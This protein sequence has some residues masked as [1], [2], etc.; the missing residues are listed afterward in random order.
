MQSWLESSAYGESPDQP[1][2]TPASPQ[3]AI[4]QPVP[5]LVFPLTKFNLRRHCNPTMAGDSKKKAPKTISSGQPNNDTRLCELLLLNCIFKHDP[6]DVDQFADIINQGKAIAHNENVTMSE[7]SAKKAMATRYAYESEPETSFLSF[8]FVGRVVKLDRRVFDDEQQDYVDISWQDYGIHGYQDRTFIQTCMKD[9]VKNPGYDKKLHD[10]SKVMSIP[11]PDLS[12]GLYKSTFTIDQ[13][14]IMESY[15]AQYQVCSG[16]VS[17]FFIVECKA[18][19]NSIDNAELQATRGAAALL[20]AQRQIDL[21]AELTFDKDGVDQRSRVFS[22][23]INPNHARLDFHWIRVDGEKPLY[24]SHRIKTYNLEDEDRVKQLRSDIYEIMDWGNNT[25]RNRV[26]ETIEALRGK[27]VV[28][29]SPK[30]DPKDTATTKSGDTATTES[31][32]SKKRKGSKS[33]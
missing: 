20:C 1:A 7:A 26:L 29:L 8:F 31:S 11:K 22:L 17:V 33:G 14:S 3:P 10:P 27:P 9:L 6:K 13:R 18:Y 12:Y 4:S 23:S 32:K 5:D 24:Y 28:D 16:L 19:T 2:S 25:H 21:V 30:E 15:V